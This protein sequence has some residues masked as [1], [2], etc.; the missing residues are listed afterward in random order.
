MFFIVLKKM[1]IEINKLNATTPSYLWKI[2]SVQKYT[3]KTRLTI[4]PK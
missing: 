4:N 3:T 1:L 2:D